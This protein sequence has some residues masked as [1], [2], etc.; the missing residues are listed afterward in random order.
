MRG[1]KKELH[2]SY[3]M[4]LKELF[5][6]WKCVL[7]AMYSLKLAVGYEVEFITPRIKDADK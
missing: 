2:F 5:R 4:R 7:K 6:L 1:N 3:I